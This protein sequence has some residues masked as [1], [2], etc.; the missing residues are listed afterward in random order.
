MATKIGSV[1]R[2]TFKTL[3]AAYDKQIIAPH[4]LRSEVAITN[5]DNILTFPILEDSIAPLK[6]EVRLNKNDIMFMTGIGMFIYNKVAN[7]EGKGVLQTFPNQIH[8][9]ATNTGAATDLETI[10]NGQLRLQV[11]TTEFLPGLDMNIFRWVPQTQQSAATNNTMD[12]EDAGFVDLATFYE[13]RGTD[14][15]LMTAKLPISPGI[16]MAALTGSN[17]LVLKM[18]GFIIKGG[19]N[20]PFLNK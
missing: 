14:Q 7:A 3:V 17:Q 19:A 2:D 5:T 20:L 6:T 10:Y 4:V 8:F 12:D 13:M 16:A 15:I 1:A 9:S 18:R 11:G